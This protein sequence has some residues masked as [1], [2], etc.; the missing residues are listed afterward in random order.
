[1][2]KQL[3][4]GLDLGTTNVKALVTDDT[5]RP[6][7]RGVV[8]NPVVPPSRWR[9][10]AGYRRNL[11]SHANSDRPGGAGIKPD[12]IKAIGISSQGG[13]MQLLDGRQRPLG[14]VISWLD[15]RGRPFDD[16]LTAEL[17]QDWFVQR[18]AHGRA[19]LA[20]GQLLRLRQEQPQL[21]AAPH[22]IGFVGDIIV[23]R[24]CGRPAQDGTSAGLTLLYNPTSRA[25]DPDLLKRL[26]LSSRQLPAL[27]AP[28]Q[29]AGGLLPEIAAKP[30]CAPAS[31]FRP[32]CTTN[33]LPRLAPARCGPGRLW[34]VPAPRGSYWQ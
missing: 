34:W 2:S 21:L 31:P 12:G 9:G 28:Q 1:M 4:L 29:P 15:Q 13:A 17:G 26:G 19:W 3:L 14:P 7:A 32:P 18:I 11:A 24:L 6:L 8:P 16:Q 27:L 5:G 33:T 22:R 25:Y 30:A 10:G 23:S 20:I